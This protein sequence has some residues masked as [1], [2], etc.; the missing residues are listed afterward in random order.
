MSRTSAFEFK[1]KALNVSKIGELLKV[2]AVVEGSVR[3]RRSIRVSTQ[4]VNVSD[5]FC[6]WSQSFD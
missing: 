4:L 2:S 1:G 3:H 5:G 6:L